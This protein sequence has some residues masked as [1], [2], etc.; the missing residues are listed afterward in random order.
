MRDVHT[1]V[2]R[3]IENCITHARNTLLVLEGARH[4]WQEA[5][6]ARQRLIELINELHK[7]F[8]R[9]LRIVQETEDRVVHILRKDIDIDTAG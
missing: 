9:I 6:S 7:V 1:I 4:E 8:F 3:G 5:H 2:D